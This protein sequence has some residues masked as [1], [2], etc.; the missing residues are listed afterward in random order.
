V[1]TFTYTAWVNPDTSGEGGVGRI[2]DKTSGSKVLSWLSTN[3]LRCLVARMTTNANAESNDNEMVLDVWQFVAGQF[4]DVA[5]FPKLFRGSIAAEVA[6]MTYA[7]QTL[8]S[9]TISSDS[10]G[11]FVLGN[12]SGGTATWDGALADF[13]LYDVI[14]SLSELKAIQRGWLV[15]PEALRLWQM[16][17][18]VVSPEPDWSGNANN[19]TLTGTIQVDGPPGRVVVPIWH[20]PRSVQRVPPAPSVG[21][22]TMRRWGGVPGMVY[23]G[24]RTW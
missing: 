20:G 22:P 14:L 23:T 3:R 9:G 24:R 15:R 16:L 4:N 18:G 1:N 7:A 8:G 21:H 10:A 12:N 17:Y 2:C 19:G 5:G 11:N 13:R 6:E